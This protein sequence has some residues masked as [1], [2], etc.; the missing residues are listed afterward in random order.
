[1]LCFV[2]AERRARGQPRRH[3]NWADRCCTLQ[4]NVNHGRTTHIHTHT[5]KIDTRDDRG[6]DRLTDAQAELE[7]GPRRCLDESVRKPPPTL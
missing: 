7:I 6:T 5:D 3:L 2:T 4:V 1:M